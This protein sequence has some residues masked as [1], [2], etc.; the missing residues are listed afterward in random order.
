MDLDF[1]RWTIE[2]GLFSWRKTIPLF[3]AGAIGLGAMGQHVSTAPKQVSISVAPQELG[4]RIPDSPQKGFAFSIKDYGP[5][6]EKDINIT[7]IRSGKGGLA[8][9]GLKAAL[10]TFDV[11]KEIAK[12]L[13]SQSSFGYSSL[14][15]GATVDYSRREEIPNKIITIIIEDWPI[16]AGTPFD[17][18][19]I[20]GT[21][22]LDLRHGQAWI[23]PSK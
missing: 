4:I 17:P 19:H 16:Y 23:A 8:D 18:I 20:T 11:K 12:Q 6:D 3:A 15:P 10:S 21:V 9:L 1:K 13:N 5:V 22:K 7:S 14:P 2:E